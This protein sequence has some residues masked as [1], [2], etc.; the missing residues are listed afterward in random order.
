MTLT[1]LRD[2]I[3]IKPDV[4]PTRTESGLHLAEH[5][6]PEQS[7]VVVSIGKAITDPQVQIGDR[8]IFSWTVGQ[9][10]WINDGAERLLVMREKDLLAVIEGEPV[11]E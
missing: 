3:L 11:Y 7:G 4:P 10:I 9:E 8:V 5:A 2:R 6:K 1:P